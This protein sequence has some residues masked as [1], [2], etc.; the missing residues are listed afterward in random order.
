ME[1][2]KV[3]LGDLTYTTLSLANEAFPLNIGYVGAYAKDV[4]GDKVDIELFKYP[5]DL[6]RAI[7]ED[8]PDVLGLSNYPWNHSLDIEFFRL[9]HELRSDTLCVMGGSNIPHE[10]EQQEVFLKSKPE[11]DVYVYLEGE[12]GFTKV[13]DRVLNGG[14]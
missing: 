13:V 5:E 11:I 7:I 8:P 10:A 2:L 14:E 3:Y 6:E 9:A 12:V 1:T 4:F